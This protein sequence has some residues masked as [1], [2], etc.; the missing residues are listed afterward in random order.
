MT[1]DTPFLIFAAVM[2]G[3]PGPANMVALSAGARFGL[4]KCTGLIL[5]LAGGKILLNI[6]MGAG[7]VAAIKDNPAVFGAAQWL[8]A[9]YM[10]WLA[11]Q[12]A[13]AGMISRDVARPLTFRDGL[14]VHPLNPKAWAMTFGAFTQ[15]T[16]PGAAWMPQVLVIIVGFAVMQLFFHTLW[17]AAGE[18]IALLV[19]GKEA[20]RI[21][22]ISLGLIMLAT[23]FWAT[24]L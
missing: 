19:A 22:M 13:G 2:V 8:S 4:R 9:A 15:F 16:D 18:R 5:G 7:L 10:I 3:T 23:L 21:L 14:I 17:C 12:I 1:A 24:A 11:W 6:A 20:E